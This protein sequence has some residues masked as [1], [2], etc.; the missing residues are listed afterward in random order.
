MSKNR[1]RKLRKLRQIFEKLRQMAREMAKVAEIQRNRE[2]RDKSRSRHFKI[3][4]DGQQDLRS[5]QK[6]VRKDKLCNIILIRI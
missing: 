5:T 1:G 4:T 2:K 3:N 6:E